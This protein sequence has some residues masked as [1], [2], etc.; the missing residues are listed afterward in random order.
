MYQ[1]YYYRIIHPNSKLYQFILLLNDT[2]RPFGAIPGRSTPATLEEIELSL[3]FSQRV[4][5]PCWLI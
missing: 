1:N 5:G 2:P 4:V 3:P